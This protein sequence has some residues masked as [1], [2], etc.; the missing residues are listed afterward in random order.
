MMTR[1]NIEEDPLMHALHLTRMFNPRIMRVINDDIL[2]E[3]NHINSG[4]E[5]LK[6]RLRDSTRS[7][8]ITYREINPA[9]SVHIIYKSRSIKIPELYRL[10]FTRL[11]LSSHE[12]R[13]ETG[14]W[15]RIPRERRLCP[16]GEIQD[17]KHVIV[18][19]PITQAIRDN[20]DMDMT[21]FTDII[22]VDSV[23]SF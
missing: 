6:Q 9:Y 23:H 13:I 16:C 19:C 18:D 15:A 3:P 11:R 4:I 22:N 20:Y 10:S 21:T 8:F 12:L 7:K 17:E 1:Q 2:S 5:I 14:R